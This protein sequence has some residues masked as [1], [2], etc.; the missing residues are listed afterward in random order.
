MQTVLHSRGR[1]LCLLQALLWALIRPEARSAQVRPSEATFPP[2][3]ATSHIPFHHLPAA[4]LVCS[5][6]IFLSFSSPLLALYF[7]V[8]QQP[9]CE[10]FSDIP[11]ETGAQ[12]HACLQTACGSGCGARSHQKPQMMKEEQRSSET[13]KQQRFFELQQP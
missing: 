3:L 10:R 12:A 7:H 6:P 8:E 9:Q 1:A 13:A 2:Q 11:C 4:S 5:S